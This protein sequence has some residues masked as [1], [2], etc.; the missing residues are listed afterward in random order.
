MMCGAILLLIG[1]IELISSDLLFK[2][3]I[4]LLAECRGF[5][6]DTNYS[7]MGFPYKYGLARVTKD[8]LIK[9]S[10]L[11]SYVFAHVKPKSP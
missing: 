8:H 7:V 5:L 3:E 11:L 10:V 4:C 1:W 2:S 9:K 6:S